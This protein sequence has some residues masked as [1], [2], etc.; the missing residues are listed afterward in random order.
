MT[1]ISSISHVAEQEGSAITFKSG[2]NDERGVPFANTVPDDFPRAGPIAS[3][4]GAQ[5]KLA[6][7]YIDGK[8]VVGRTPAEL[9]VRYDNCQDLAIQLAAYCTRKATANPEWSQGFNLQRVAGGM[10]EK[11]MNGL[12]DVTVAEQAWVMER[13]KLILGW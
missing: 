1:S 8:Y 13:V 12:W 5:A 6:A 11:V 4:A 7:R 2:K 3:V 9:L 10:S